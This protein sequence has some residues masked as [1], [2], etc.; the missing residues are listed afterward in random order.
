VRVWRVPSSELNR[1]RPR[2]EIADRMTSLRCRRTGAQPGAERRGASREVQVWRGGGRSE[3]RELARERPGPRMFG[4]WRSRRTASRLV[5]RLR[6]RGGRGSGDVAGEGRGDRAAR[7][8]DRPIQAVAFSPDGTRVITGSR[9]LTARVWSAD[10]GGP[11]GDGAGAARRRGARG[12]VLAGRVARGHGLEWTGWCGVVAGRRRRPGRAGGAPRR[13]GGG[14]VLAGRDAGRLGVDRRDGAGAPRRRQ[15]RTGGP[16]RR[17][18]GR[19]RAGVLAGRGAASSA[20]DE[21]DAGVAEQTASARRWCSTCRALSAAFSADG[22]GRHARAGRARCARGRCAR[23]AACREWFWRG[24]SHCLSA[25]RRSALL[26]EERAAAEQRI[27]PT[28]G[29][30]VAT[31]AA[32]GVVSLVDDRVG[33]GQV[34]SRR[35][36]GR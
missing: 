11:R 8:T 33:A 29:R 6:G 18:V 31:L 15:R 10:E 9:D 2:A 4:R 26:G 30:R 36:R 16:A 19:A 25:D 14:G 23:L 35:R 7:G 24:T 13:R 27:W 34:V 28:A 17:E 20:L 22:P 3:P 12:G 1:P 21:R 5:G 32:Q